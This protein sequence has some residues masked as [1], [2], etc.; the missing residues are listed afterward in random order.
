MPKLSRPQVEAIARGL[1]FIASSDGIDERETKMIRD[2]LKEAG[3]A[4]LEAKISDGSF[5]VD[6]IAA[7]LDS[8]WLREIFL[9]VS[10]LLVKADGKMTVPERRAIQWVAQKLQVST[11]V[12]QLET[13]VAKERL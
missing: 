4:D 13:S 11:P 12:D 8:E 3:A 6:K 2:F 9:K 1:F 10:I 7:A 5:D